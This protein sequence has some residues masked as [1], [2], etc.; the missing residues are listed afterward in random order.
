MFLCYGP[1]INGETTMKKTKPTPVILRCP[2]C[3]SDEFTMPMDTVN[4]VRLVIT[5]EP[6][7][8]EDEV[9]SSDGDCGEI[10]CRQCDSQW[11]E[12]E[13]QEAAMKLRAA[14]S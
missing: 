1:A 6:P 12:E 11:D 2:Q 14:A 9:I 5:D 7:Y 10:S 3:G 4:K 13:L 8:Y